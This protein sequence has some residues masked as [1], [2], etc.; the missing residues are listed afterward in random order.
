M[1]KVRS[2]FSL[3]AV[4][5]VL[6][7]A[8]GASP[9]AA[10]QT[11]VFINEI[12]YDNVGTDAGEAIEVAGPAG[13]DLTG[14]SIVLY[15]GSNSQVY[16]TDVLS[17]AIPDQQGGFGT[18]F[19]SYPENGIQNGSPD[20]LALVDSGNSVLQFLSY[21]GTI[22]ALGGPADGMTS[23]DIGV[24]QGGSGPVGNSL[25]L[26]G[27]GSVYEDFTWQP[28]APNT[29]GAVNTEQTFGDGGPGTPELVINEI[30][31]DQPS[32]DTAEFVEIKNNGGSDANLDNVTLELVNGTGGGA[33]IYQTYDLPDVTLAA[34]DY[35]VVCANASI[36]ANC[37]LDVSP[38]TNLIQNGDPDA[39]GLRFNGDLLDA[40]SYEGDS[41]AP[42]TEGS[43]AGLDDS[44]SNAGEGISRCPDG[45]DSDQNNVDFALAAITPGAAND[46][47]VEQPD[48][49]INELRIDQPST[50]NDEYFELAGTAGGSLEGL[51]YLVIGD[52]TAG[53]GVLEAVVDLS[54]NTIPSSG[55]FVAAEGTFTLGTADLTTNLN[56]EN[57]DNVT[58]LL[59]RDFSGSN[60]DDLDTDDDGTLDTTPWSEQVDCVALIQTETPSEQIYCD[61]TVGPDGTFTPGHAYLCDGE[62]VIGAFAPSQDTPGAENDCDGGSG[63][64]IGMCGDPATFIHEVQGSG[65]ASPIAGQTVAVEGVVVGDFQN[66]G[67]PDNGELNG[68]YLQEEDAD[69][70]ADAATSEGVFIFGSTI[71]VQNGDVVRALGSIS[72]FFNRTEISVSEA[73]VCAS[74][75]T[76]TATVVTLPVD[77]IEDLEAYEGMSVVF[78]QDL[79]IA[80]YF[81]FDRFNEIV[82]ATERQFQPTAV[83]EPGSPEAAD[84]AIENR[85]SR[86][87]LDD[88][89]NSANPDPALHPDGDVFDLGNLFR[90]GDILRNVTGVMD[91]AFG[92]YRIQPTQGAEHIVDNPRS[93]E[94]DDVGGDI[95]VASFNVLNYFTT[96]DEGQDNCGPSGTLECRGADTLEELERQRAKI[97]AAIAAMDS[98][99][100]GLI[101]IQNDEGESTE[102]LVNGLND[103]VGAGT[104]DYIDTGFIGTDAIKQAFIYQPGSVTPVGDFAVLDTPEFE[105]PNNSGS[106]K[107]RPALAQTFMDNESSGVFTAVVNHLKS[108]GSGCGPGDDDPEQGNC[109]LTR[110]L[111]AQI[112]ADWLA[113]DPTS[114]G[115]ADFLII[116][117]LNAYD[118]ED[119]IEVLR[120]N[121]YTDLVAQ[122]GGEFAY[123]YVFDGQL[124]YLDHALANASLLPNVTGTT[125]WHI[126][127][128]EA[129]LIDYDMTFKQDAQD[130]LY[131]P[132]A[133]RSS[134]H[135]PVI[136]GLQF[137]PAN[138]PPDCSGAAPSIASL[139]PPSHQFVSIDILGVTDPDG[140]AVTITIDSIFQDEAV[141][142]EDSGNTAPDGTGVGTSTAQVRAERVETGNGRVY[143]ISFTATDTAGGSCSGEV[144]VSVSVGRRDMAVD[145]GPLFDSTAL[146]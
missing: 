94:P 132:D 105:D 32:T 81:N 80:E 140:D 74:G 87:T 88:G 25:Q 135:D 39:V 17:G 112:L 2:Y 143:H 139:W 19:I 26:A 13:T 83:Y 138:A 18:V 144:L 126:N 106:P 22:T 84:L 27:T 7:V 10:A 64:E 92:L 110:A 38:D 61:T 29:F 48:V 47:A 141:D 76:V 36:V 57:S 99:V 103:L 95:Q 5:L 46:C 128:D 4:L 70:D 137:E 71:D 145:D 9:Q 34:D 93:A 134:D 43:G 122:F 125:V 50:D 114:S 53:S 28:E 11:S 16:D 66:N 72:E 130:E 119:P 45:V 109:N 56:F 65:A 86:I 117:D 15:N 49:S 136:V 113:T 96:I 51:T 21:E 77:T 101:E 68:F 37:D 104:Y 23:T 12:H 62:W 123:S 100:V 121:G 75:A 124:G 69:A 33:S 142:A 107:N 73:L 118:K 90:G 67:Q 82:L 127:A 79:Y 24:S 111:S 1:A 98:D 44:G 55:F 116:G 59:V 63:G 3:T 129:D 30:D 40:V 85:L 58:H 108:K 133:Y 6:V 91:F 89:R 54:G 41:G 115:D 42:Y 120:D 35:F 131:A 78:T 31:Y 146:P 52:G 102:D 97:V 60:G 8:L 14:W 20:G